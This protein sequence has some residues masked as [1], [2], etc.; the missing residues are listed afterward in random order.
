MSTVV[1]AFPEWGV[2]DGAVKGALGA[3][4]DFQIDGVGHSSTV[5]SLMTS[6]E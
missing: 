1:T 4:L 2:D 6:H 3:A 5:A